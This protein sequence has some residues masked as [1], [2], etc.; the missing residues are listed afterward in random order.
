MTQ[1]ELILANLDWA[2]DLARSVYYARRREHPGSRLGEV[3]DCVSIAHIE[4]VKRA[5]QYDPDKNDSFRGYAAVAVKG[6]VKMYFRS[7]LRS[8][9]HDPYHVEVVGDDGHQWDLLTTQ[10]A[11]PEANAALRQIQVAVGSLPL[12]LRVVAYRHLL[13]QEPLWRLGRAL[14]VPHKTLQRARR[15]AL[16]QIEVLCGKL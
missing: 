2:A 3:E 11:E 8:P 14:G 9:N 13:C 4:L 15:E 7:L 5:R 1:E 6:A 12:Q 16:R 10:A